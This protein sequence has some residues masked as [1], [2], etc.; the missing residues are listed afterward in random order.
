MR[1]PL[2]FQT[3]SYKFA[4]WKMLPPETEY[5]VSYIESRGGEFD[6]TMFFGLQM[7]LREYATER[8]TVEMVKKAKEFVDAHMG[9]GL[10]NYDMWMYIAVDLNGRLPIIIEAVPEGMVIPVKNVLVQIRNTD[11]KCASLVSFIE[12]SLLRAVWYPT[13]VGTTSWHI[14]QLIKEYMIKTCDNLDKL[15]FML[16]DFSGRGNTSSESAGLASAAHLVNFMGTDTVE[17]ILYAQHYYNTDKMVGFSIPASEHSVTCAW[18]KEGE[19]DFINNMI[20]QFGKPG[21][22]F[23]G[24]SDTYDL[25]NCIENIWGSDVLKNKLVSSGATAVVRPDSGDPT[26]VPIN[27][28]D[29][30]MQNFGFE[31]NSVGYDLLPSSIRLIQGDGMNYSSLGELLENTK[32]AYMSLDNFAYGMG[33]GLVIHNRDDQKFAMKGSQFIVD[34]EIRNVNK[35]P[36]TDPGKASKKGRFCLIRENGKWETVQYND[37]WN[38]ANWLHVVYSDGRIV[39]EYTWDEVVANSNLEALN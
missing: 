26:K 33:G 37:S 27:A 10:F 3:D 2:I 36:I 24:V 30:L 25:W 8:V 7:W 21:A 16:H 29:L 34:G 5:S 1:V 32:N 20:N 22:L 15:P 6:R 23:A 39:K 12:T 9:P 38:W 11:S 19:R 31:T 13:T 35:D 4:H 14:K 28:A 17:G 18:G